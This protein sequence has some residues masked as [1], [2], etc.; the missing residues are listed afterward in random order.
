MH[1]DSIRTSLDDLPH[2][3][4]CLLRKASYA[5]V[6]MQISSCRP[7]DT[8]TVRRVSLTFGQE[9]DA[10]VFLLTSSDQRRYAVLL[11]CILDDLPLRFTIYKL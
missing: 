2:N 9:R 8:K 4:P 10:S 1:T 7:N 6:L 5:S 3:L 11:V